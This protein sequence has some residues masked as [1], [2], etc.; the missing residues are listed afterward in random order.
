MLR[1]IALSVVFILSSLLPAFGN[2]VSAPPAD[3]NFTRTIELPPVDSSVVIRQQQIKLNRKH[4]TDA[5]RSTLQLDLFDNVSFEILMSKPS[6]T[7][8]GSLIREGT[9]VG[10]PSGNVLFIIHDS[11]VSGEITFLTTLY[12]IRTLDNGI[13]I[14]QEVKN[15]VRLTREVGASTK[16]VSNDV[17]TLTNQERAKYGIPALAYNEQLSQSA[18]GHAD[19]MVQNN[20]YSHYSQDGRSFSDRITAA[21]YIWN[22]ASENIARGQST[23]TIVVND[24]INSPD[25]HK[26]MLDTDVC[27]IG[28]GH[29]YSAGVA[30][31]H[32]W[33]QNFGRK[34]AI[35]TCPTV[36]PPPTGKQP[37]VVTGTATSISA[38]STKL[39]GTV[40]PNG[41]DTSYY[42]EI[43]LTIAYGFTSQAYNAGSGIEP[44]TVQLNVSGFSAATTYH[45]RIV[46]YNNMGTTYGKDVAFILRDKK[47][48]IAL[49]SLLLSRDTPDYTSEPASGVLTGQSDAQLAFI[50][51]RGYPHLFSL[52]FITEGIDKSGYVKPLI[53]P[54]RMESWAYN[55]NNFSSVLFDNGY[56][57]KETNWGIR[58]PLHAT[59]LKPEQFTLG[60]TEA[61]IISI[62][63]TPSCVETY[64]LAGKTYQFLRYNPTNNSPA[65]TVA[66]ENGFL[67]SVTAG[68]A[69]VD[70]SHTGTNLCMPQ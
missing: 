35:S 63:G 25:H 33:V 65:A 28:I 66:I 58:A 45:F 8:S 30:Y 43:G 18:Q 48:P 44:L 3:L 14:A 29:A 10:Y 34:S 9:V 49:L 53:T 5:K 47:L 60:M 56:F 4:L 6:R 13:H 26:N 31:N 2:S 20:Y 1:C 68:Y 32:Y 23:A 24:W 70:S 15:S 41:L 46:A 22:R 50:N 37:D 39:T 67:Q 7:P 19:D 17:I 21:G 16:G 59:Q 36:S 57:I 62:M 61:Q 54:R 12:Q 55:G 11:K 27:D 51:Q 38:D 52:S 64:S 42:Y 40:N 69:L